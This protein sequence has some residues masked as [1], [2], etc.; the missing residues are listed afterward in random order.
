MWTEN[1][2]SAFE[3]ELIEFVEN[4]ILFWAETAPYKVGKYTKIFEI[5]IYFEVFAGKHCFSLNC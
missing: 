1:S 3:E 5:L 2:A 4:E